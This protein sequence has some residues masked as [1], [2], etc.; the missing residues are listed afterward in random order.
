MVDQPFLDD[1]V[2]H[3]GQH[4]DVGA[5]LE[6]QPQLGE[7]DQFDAAGVD[8]DHFCAILTD[9]FLHLQG[10]DGMVLGRVRAGHDHDVIVDD[11]AGGIAH[12]RRANR[13]L[14]RH[15]AA[16][17][18]ETGAVVHVVGAEQRPEHLLQQVVVFVGGLGAAVDGHGIRAVALVDLYQPIS[19]IIQGFIPGNFAPVVAVEGLGAFAAVSA[20]F[21]ESNGV[22]TR[23]RGW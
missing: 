10:D 11:F 9:G 13:L 12:R 17:M 15:H 14:E 20:V 23:L 19:N 8:D 3:R 21:C 5:R 18:T 7:I 4:R 16:R 22:V 2:R 1:D 6:R